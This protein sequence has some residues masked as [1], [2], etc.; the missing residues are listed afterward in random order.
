MPA[1]PYLPHENPGQLLCSCKG[2]RHIGICSHCI[3]V[4]HWLQELDLDEIMTPLEGEKKSKKRAG[5]MKGVRPALIKEGITK[6]KAK[7]KKKANKQ[8]T[9]RK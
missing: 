5:Y 4:G 3:A 9:Q 2:F 8:L 7:P 1:V 6:K